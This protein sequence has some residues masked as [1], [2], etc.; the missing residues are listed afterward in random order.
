MA[1]ENKTHYVVADTIQARA[2][3][4]RDKGYVPLDEYL[5]SSRRH[6]A[7]GEGLKSK[8][9]GGHSF[10]VNPDMIDTCMEL[11]QARK[12]LPEV[13]ENLR[14]ADFQKPWEIMICTSPGSGTW[15]AI[16]RQMNWCNETVGAY[17]A[18]GSAQDITRQFRENKRDLTQALRDRKLYKHSLS[19]E[20][21]KA[22]R[23]AAQKYLDSILP[24]MHKLDQRIQTA[25][26]TVQ[27]LRH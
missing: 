5:Q 19:Q 23:D 10:W 4:M 7:F 24:E 21:K 27:H 11:Q 13:P 1:S 3:V 2:E 8:G 17:E 16:Q 9:K 12:P 25:R 6:A 20:F 15:K 14:S 18:N 26:Q 22:G